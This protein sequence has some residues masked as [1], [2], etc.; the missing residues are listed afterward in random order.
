MPRDALPAPSAGWRAALALGFERRGERTVLA[1]NRSDGPLVVQKA[2]HPEGPGT[3][4][5]IVVHPPAGIVGGDDLD[6]TVQA[7]AGSHALLTT[8]GAAKWY[9]RSPRFARQRVA[10]H[11]A[12]GAV[13]EW[14]PQES[15]VFDG[16]LADQG[17]EARLEGDATLVAW[18]IQCLGR[19]GSG[20]SFATGECRTVSSLFRDGR[21]AWRERGRIA[22][23]TLATSSTAALSGCAVF[24]TLV[25][26]TTRIDDESLQAARAIAPKAGAGGVTRLP[27]LL[28]ARYRGGSAGAAREYFTAIWS[29]LRLAL[30]GRPAA[31]PRIWST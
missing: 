7:A 2:L 9:G 15:I 19:S 3:C 26:A 23:G 20:E 8:P 27:G 25:F 28:V 16:A 24:G 17:W 10:L 21:L 4:H 18:D 14:L 5:A 6:I 11:V 22:A 30:A 12:P 1:A 29:E 13:V 31:I